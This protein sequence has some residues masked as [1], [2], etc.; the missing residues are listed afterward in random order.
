M[1]I[2]GASMLTLR[3]GRRFLSRP[4]TGSEE[5][6]VVAAL[7]LWKQQ[8]GREHPLLAT[9]LKEHRIRAMDKMTFARPEE[10]AAFGYTDERKRILLNPNLC[11][12]CQQMLAPRFCTGIADA[13]L[14]AT[15]AT[16]QHEVRHLVS[17]ASEALAYEDEWRYVCRT[18]H[19]CVQHQM[20]GLSLEL[21]EWERHLPTRV[22]LHVGPSAAEP[23]EKRISSAE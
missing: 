15:L 17:G 22:R 13:D 8:E 4:L 18:R 12:T 21:L 14:V 11:F 20:P 3:E 6:V 16:L 10:R 19:W 1:L 2:F 9:M 7:D 23:M 5:R